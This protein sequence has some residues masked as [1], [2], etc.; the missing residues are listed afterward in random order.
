[1]HDVNRNP[2]GLFIY[3][4]SRMVNSS[5]QVGGGFWD[6]DEG[7][8]LGVY[9]TLENAM[10]I[11]RCETLTPET[12]IADWHPVEIG[13]DYQRVWACIVQYKIFSSANRA[14]YRIDERRVDDF[15]HRV[16]PDYFKGL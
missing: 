6:V 14:V 8:F 12:I 11:A 10:Q 3:V 2:S 1:M 5:Y 9:S 15:M 4:L 13:D 16:N 7:A